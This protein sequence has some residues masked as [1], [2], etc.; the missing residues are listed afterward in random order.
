ML[1]II[2]ISSFCRMVYPKTISLLKCSTP[3]LLTSSRGLSSSSTSDKYCVDLVKQYDYE[4]YMI[5][6]LFP[7]ATQRGYFAIRAFNVE[8]ATIKDQTNNNPLTGRMRFQWWKDAIKDIYSRKQIVKSTNIVSSPIAGVKNQPV[9]ESLTECI[10]ENELSLRWFEHAIDARQKDLAGEVPQRL[11][12]LEDYSESAHSSIMYLLLELLKVKHENSEYIASHIGVCV[13]IVTILRSF[14][15]HKSNGEIYIPDEILSKYNITAK[16]LLKK[17]SLS[18][19][20]KEALKNSLF[21]IGSQAFGH[22]DRARTLI[23]KE[24][25]PKT[26]YAILPGV[27]AA[28]YLEALRK[29]DFN[30]YNESVESQN[31]LLSVL[32]MGKAIVTKSV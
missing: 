26:V 19:E 18:V 23:K 9:L 29:A 4:N 2:N 27:L 31:H 24:M 30:P 5:G 10:M 13:G 32:R 15:Y 12:D 16:M 28:S 3:S 20:E 1:P 21:D 22:L 17:E 11:S 7:A 25:H 14:H 6:N 8:I